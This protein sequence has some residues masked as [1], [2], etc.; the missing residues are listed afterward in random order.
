MESNIGPSTPALILSK[1]RSHLDNAEDSYMIAGNPHAQKNKRIRNPHDLTQSDEEHTL[2]R[3]IS[4]DN[5]SSMVKP[6][7]IM[8]NIQPDNHKKS[9]TGELSSARVRKSKSPMFLEIHKR[10]VVTLH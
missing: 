7:L 6:S 1:A 3:D 9:R 4:H 5:A 2:H 8:T 10:V